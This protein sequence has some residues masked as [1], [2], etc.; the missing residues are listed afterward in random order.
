MN[1][2]LPVGPRPSM[3]PRIAAALLGGYAFTWGFMALSLGG[4]YALGL[5][6]HDAEHLA[7]LLGLLLYL[8][9]FLWAFAARSLWRVWVVL[10]GGGALMA[11]AASLLQS[12]LVG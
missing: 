11:G 5:P 9:A 12:R 3:V 8:A 2:V 10:G 1:T 7:A 6:F 4:L